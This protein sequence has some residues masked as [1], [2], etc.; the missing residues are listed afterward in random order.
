MPN[1]TAGLI[2]IVIVGK[3]KQRFACVGL[4]PYTRTDGEKTM[5]AVWEAACRVCGLPFRQ[6]SSSRVVNPSG[7][8]KTCQNHRK[9]KP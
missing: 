1:D 5:L 6:A 2:G 3:A 7:M 4:E 8:T 9:S